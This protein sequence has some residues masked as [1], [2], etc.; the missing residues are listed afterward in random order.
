MNNFDIYS[1]S[2]NDIIHNHL[3]ISHENIKL[4]NEII[5]LKNKHT[6]LLTSLEGVM[7]DKTCDMSDS[8]YLCENNVCGN[9]I[10]SEYTTICCECKCISCDDCIN[11]DYEI[12]SEYHRCLDCFPRGDKNK[13]EINKNELQ[14]YII[15]LTKFPKD[16]VKY[17]II[18]YINAIYL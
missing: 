13:F 16:I 2:A 5:K 18:P 17:I 12:F 11:S 4:K 7:N 6:A 9:I 8:Y 10:H 3:I 14:K 1:A 15:Y